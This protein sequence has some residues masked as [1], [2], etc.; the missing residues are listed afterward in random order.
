MNRH[1]RLLALAASVAYCPWLTHRECRADLFALG[2]SRAEIHRI[3]SISGTLVK[4]YSILP[5]FSAPTTR[6]GLAF[7]G[8]TLYVTL[9]TPAGP[10]V[11]IARF[12]VVEEIWLPPAIVDAPT[13][14]PPVDLAD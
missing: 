4:T 3:D 7:D 13:S 12:D 2:S 9:G 11:E 1:I 10:F 6:S 5:G 14:F 8:R